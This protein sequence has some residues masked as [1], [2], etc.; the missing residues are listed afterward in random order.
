MPKD[1]TI[2]QLIDL[3]EES[4]AAITILVHYGTPDSPKE[5]DDVPFLAVIVVRGVPETGDILKMIEEYNK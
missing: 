5:Y 3:S 1:L 4:N 2:Q